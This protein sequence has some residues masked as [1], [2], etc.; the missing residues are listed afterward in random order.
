MDLKP[1]IHKRQ[2]TRQIP[3][4]ASYRFYIAA[5]IPRS[6]ISEKTDV[7]F[8]IGDNNAYGMYVN[9]PLSAGKTYTMYVAYISRFNKTVRLCLFKC[10]YDLLIYRK[11]M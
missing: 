1:V 8:T 9:F 5:E 7:V 2:A 4:T 11:D 3:D 6:D 10:F